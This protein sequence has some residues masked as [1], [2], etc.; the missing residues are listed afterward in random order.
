MAET[1]DRGV[2]PKP[3]SLSKADAAPVREGRAT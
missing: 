2:A 1:N 3:L